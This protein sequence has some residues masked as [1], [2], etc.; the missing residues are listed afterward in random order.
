MLLGEPD[1]LLAVAGLAHDVETAVAEHLDDVE[2]D[3]RLV[4]GDDDA[5]GGAGGRGL[6]AS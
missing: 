3:Q 4:L 6:V 1:G 5:A 2:A